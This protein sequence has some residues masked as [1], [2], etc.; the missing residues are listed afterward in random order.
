MKL[1]FIG[2]GAVGK[3]LYDV[4]SEKYETCFFDIQIINSKITDIL[5]ADILFIAVPTNLNKNDECDLS[6][7]DD[8]MEQLFNLKYKG[9]ICIKSTILPDTTVNYIKKYNNQN[10]CFCPEFLKERCAYNDFKYNNKICIIGTENENVYTN[11]KNVHEFICSEFR[12]VSPTEAELTK[13][14][15]NVY[16]TNKILFANA[17]YEICKSKN[18]VYDNIIDN[19]L[20]RKEID[21]MYL[22]CND[23][24]RGPSGPCL[25]K[26]TVAFNTY[27]NS[28]NKE[29]S[30]TIF[31]S[32]VN[33][34]KL[35]PKSVI[36]GTRPEKTD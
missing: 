18:I 17:F 34:I 6:I 1:G 19:L 29:I 15:Q 13:Y 32:L 25:V 20:Y 33:D 31:Q 21:S 16:N 27:V 14:F 35:Y 5:I 28:L 3:T 2:L 26:D 30:P 22:K 8:I 4:F 7:L 10:I 36:K 11:I 24:L 9:I 12:K 23:E